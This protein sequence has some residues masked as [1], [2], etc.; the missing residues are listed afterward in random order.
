[1]PATG[2]ATGAVELSTRDL[3]LGKPDQ[4]LSPVSAI[5]LGDN[6]GGKFR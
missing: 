5:D 1:V 3:L 6:V 2:T 4:V